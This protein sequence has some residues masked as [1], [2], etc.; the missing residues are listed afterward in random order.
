MFS[1]SDPVSLMS[2]HETAISD[3]NIIVANTAVPML[4]EASAPQKEPSKNISETLNFN[5]A[6]WGKI[7][8]W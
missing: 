4:K 6:D 5:K 1:S 2:V 7:Y 3:H 8:Y